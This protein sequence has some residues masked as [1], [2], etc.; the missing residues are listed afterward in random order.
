MVGC[1]SSISISTIP[2]GRWL[3]VSVESTLHSLKARR[4]VQDRGLG[5][6]HRDYP[7]GE[8]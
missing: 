6:P 3:D 2:V 1:P 4:T 5:T 8:T 7:R